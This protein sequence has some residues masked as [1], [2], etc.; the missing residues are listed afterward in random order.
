[1]LKIIIQ[2]IY[3]VIIIIFLIFIF[4]TYFSKTNKIN[5]YNKIYGKYNLNTVDINKLPFMENDTDDVIIFNHDN[6]IDTK[7]KK[8]KI[9]DLLK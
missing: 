2:L 7:F 3:I 8:R 9:W 1:M 5:T 4:S 6:N